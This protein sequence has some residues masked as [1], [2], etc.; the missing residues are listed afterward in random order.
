MNHKAIFLCWKLRCTSYNNINPFQHI[1][2]IHTIIYYL[3]EWKHKNLSSKRLQPDT[4]MLLILF[5]LYFNRYQ[6]I[7]AFVCINVIIS[8]DKYCLSTPKFHFFNVIDAR[9]VFI[10][11]KD[12]QLYKFLVSIIRKNFI[13]LH[14]PVYNLHLL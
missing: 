6:Y 12:L 14:F 7:T 10:V 5:F 4:N 11:F 9:T 2:S 8:Y 3:W 13:S 1:Y